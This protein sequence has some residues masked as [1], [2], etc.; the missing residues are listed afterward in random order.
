[1]RALALGRDPDG[2][3]GAGARARRTSALEAAATV[4]DRMST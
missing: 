3:G 4:T 2:R 1:M